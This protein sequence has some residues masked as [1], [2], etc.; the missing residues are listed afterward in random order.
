MLYITKTVGYQCAVY[1]SDD[2]TIEWVSKEDIK[3]SGFQFQV[4][5]IRLRPE[6]CNF[7]RNREN[8]FA[9][10]YRISK[11]SGV[12]VMTSCGKK[13]KFKLEGD[14]LH[15]TIGV[16]VPAKGVNLCC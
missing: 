14:M 6:Q 13:F 7:G 2:G 5:E 10:P 12:Y 8:I 15:F 1:D 4:G 11:V 16:Y 9:S 3:R